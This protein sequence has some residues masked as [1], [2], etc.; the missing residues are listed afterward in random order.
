M[1]YSERQRIRRGAKMS[2]LQL[3]RMTPEEFFAWQAK[4]DKL[5]ELVDGLPVLPLKMM[6]GASRAH[7]RVV[8]NIIRELANQL[9]GGPYQPTTPGPRNPCSLR[10]YQ[11]S[12]YCGRV[13]QR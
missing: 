12:R 6:T 2:E 7:D 8:V 9:R 10:E 5:Y 3:H 4:Q 13:R 1:L 11:A